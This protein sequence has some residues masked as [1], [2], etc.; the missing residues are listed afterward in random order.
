MTG[1]LLGPG[2]GSKQKPSSDAQSSDDDERTMPEE[3]LLLNDPKNL[4]SK[5]WSG[6]Y[7]CHQRLPNWMPQRFVICVLAHFG[8]IFLY[9][10]RSN[11]SLAIVRMTTPYSLLETDHLIS[12]VDYDWSMKEQGIILGS[13]F[14]GY[15]LTQIPGGYLAVRYGGRMV[16]G[17]GVGF[18]AI[19]SLLTPLFG[20]YLGFYGFVLA[21]ALCGI[22]E[23]VTYPAIHAMWSHWAPPKERTTLVSGAFA[24]AYLGAA[25]SFTASSRDASW[26]WLF[27]SAG[28]YSFIWTLLWFT[29]G[30]EYPEI[31]EVISEY[32]LNYLTETVGAQ[33]Y[34]QNPSIP[35]MKILLSYRVWAIC[36][37]HFAANWGFYT[38]LTELPTFMRHALHFHEGSLGNIAALPFLGMGIT[39]AFGGYLVD[40]TLLRCLNVTYTRKVTIALTFLA[41]MM[42]FFYAGKATEG[43]EFMICICGALFFGGLSWA[44]FGANHLD[45]APDYASILLGI[46]NTAGTIPG[47]IS[48]IV[49]G[50]LVENKEELASWSPVFLLS[51]YVYLVAGIYYIV[52]GTG[53]RQDWAD[54]N[55]AVKLNSERKQSK[56]NDVES[57]SD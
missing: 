23:G 28:L 3:K 40:N 33:Q 5:G 53:E 9:I 12:Q 46:T 18:A 16:F 56:I 10:M 26:E 47:I 31:D 32:E 44:G 15:I 48:P 21:R 22:C 45:I 8:F 34:T 38:I 19:S 39:A 51:G 24:G 41:Q 13:F 14:F 36:V 11:M 50:Y 35:W 54:A 17:L 1:K 57:A 7:K 2:S 30:N 4:Q 42:F 29:W 52:F 43:Y 25:I 49:T 6:W 37:C 27:L 20:H 55:E